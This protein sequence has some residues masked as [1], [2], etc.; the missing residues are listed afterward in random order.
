M[1]SFVIYIASELYDMI[2]L[3]IFNFLTTSVSKI[4]RIPDYF[5]GCI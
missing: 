5:L 1:Q 4:L 2:I 3:F